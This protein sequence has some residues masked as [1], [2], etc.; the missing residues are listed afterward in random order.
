VIHLSIRRA[1]RARSHLKQPKCFLLITRHK[2]TDPL[3]FGVAPANL[4]RFSRE[5]ILVEF[6]REFFWLLVH[7]CLLFVVLLL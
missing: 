2:H 4:D 7:Y 3:H 5:K 6:S 1:T